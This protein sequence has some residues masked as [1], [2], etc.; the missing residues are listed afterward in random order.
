M[1]RPPS[2]RAA[3]FFGVEITGVVFLSSASDMTQYIFGYDA[4]YAGTI[5]AALNT[6]NFLGRVGFGFLSDKVSAAPR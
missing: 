5:T 6:V 4:A 2:R 1:T 3:Q